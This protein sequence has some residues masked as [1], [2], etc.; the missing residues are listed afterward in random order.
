MRQEALNI[1]QGPYVSYVAPRSAQPK[2]QASS[3]STLRLLPLRRKATPPPPQSVLSNPRPA[4]LPSPYSLAPRVRLAA[5]APHPSLSF[6]FTRSTFSA[7]FHSGDDKGSSHCQVF[8][9]VDY[10]AF[11]GP[12]TNI[13]QVCPSIPFPS[14]GAEPKPQTLMYAIYIWIGLCI[15]NF[16][17]AIYRVYT[18]VLN[19][20]RPCRTR[21][22]GK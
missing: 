21:T 18:H 22:R 8:L 19:W 4:E 15:G 14:C 10:L 13:R 1:K 20:V 11:V 6:A 9:S 17:Q 7:L 16:F 3:P 2:A 5:E 12:V